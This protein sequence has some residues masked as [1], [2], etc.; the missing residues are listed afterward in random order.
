MTEGLPTKNKPYH[1]FPLDR[2]LTFGKKVLAFKKR[3]V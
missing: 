1:F 2:N 3:N